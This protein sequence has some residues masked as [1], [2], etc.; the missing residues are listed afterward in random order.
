VCWYD[1]IVGFI[2]KST[3]GEAYLGVDRKEPF[4]NSWGFIEENK[5]RLTPPCMRAIIEQLSNPQEHLHCGGFPN[6]VI[7]VCQPD[8]F[9]LSG[10][11]DFSLKPSEEA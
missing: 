5:R 7:P 6:I 3:E 4:G 11:G 1:D 9:L 10:K 8:L 2:L